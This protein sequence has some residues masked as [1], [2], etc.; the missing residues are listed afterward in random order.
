MGNL[1]QFVL[2][3]N[4]RG[5]RNGP[6]LSQPLF[7]ASLRQLGCSTLW[8]IDESKDVVEASKR[9]AVAVLAKPPNGRPGAVG[10][11]YA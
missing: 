10:S 1:T 5:T 2:S 7:Q 4:K 9:G 8:D 3:L 11:G 6:H